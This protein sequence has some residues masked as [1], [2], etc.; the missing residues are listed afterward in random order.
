MLFPAEP[1]VLR[2]SSSRRA[3]AAWLAAIVGLLMF[4]LL[5]A[6]ASANP[7]V[8]DVAIT[9]TADRADAA[10]GDAVTWTVT[11]QNAG[12]AEVPLASIS[13]DDPGVVLTAAGAT[14][15]GDTLRP[16][17]AL[18][19]T[20]QTAVTADA[21]PLMSNTATVRLVSPDL[22]A[23]NGKRPRVKPVKAPKKGTKG[24]KGK[25]GKKPPPPPPPAPA[26]VDVNPA[27]DTATASVTVTCPPPP[28]GGIPAVLEPAPPVVPVACPVPD[29][30]VGIVAPRSIRAGRP[31]HVA[32]TVHN[33]S[34]SVAA[35]AVVARYALP[36]GTAL[37]RL[38]RGARVLRGR[39]V[40]LRVASLAPG[41]SRTV[42]ILLRPTA[43]VVHRRG[44]R[45]R[46]SEQCTGVRTAVTATRVK[47]SRP[48]RRPPP[49]TG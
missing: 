13:V 29:L 44:H 5:P 25:G 16:G 31:I 33:A 45:A 47:N 49:V 27:N 15:A 37:A 11:V 12:T 1:G 9:K 28:P 39:S 4:A 32:V 19:L 46:A 3:R 40:V 6:A 2:S 42:R 38:P 41:A 26:P 34:S 20:G 18:T 24:T 14:P 7:P 10:P 22:A 48:R 36:R 30:K 8:T 35:S 21:C 23:L 43:I 17:E